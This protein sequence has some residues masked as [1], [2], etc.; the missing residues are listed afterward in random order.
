MGCAL[1][2]KVFTFKHGL[3]AVQAV[4]DQHWFNLVGGC[5]PAPILCFQKAVGFAPSLGSQYFSLQWD[6]A[7]GQTVYSDGVL[8]GLSLCPGGCTPYG[9]EAADGSL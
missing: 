2:P 3:Q 9:E 8:R 7:S 4:L 5:L 1:T 6:V